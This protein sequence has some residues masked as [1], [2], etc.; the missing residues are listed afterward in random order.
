MQEGSARVPASGRTAGEL[1]RSIPRRDKFAPTEHLG[2]PVIPLNYIKNTLRY[3]HT[4][5]ARCAQRAGGRTELRTA[6][7]GP[8]PGPPAHR[9]YPRHSNDCLGSRDSRH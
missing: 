2:F 3:R 1:L 8:R 6:P 9:T 5:R 7:I 4:D